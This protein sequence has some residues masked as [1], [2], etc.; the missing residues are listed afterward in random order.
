LS[1]GRHDAGDHIKFGFP[2]AGST[3]VLVWGLL[4]FTDAY[5]QTG[6]LA[7]AL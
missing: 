6:E 1:S 5:Q 7:N 2:M 4:L 3:T